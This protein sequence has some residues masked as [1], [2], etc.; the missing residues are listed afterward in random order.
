MNSLKGQSDE[1][2]DNNT[3]MEVSMNSLMEKTQ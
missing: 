1:I 3:D 2:A